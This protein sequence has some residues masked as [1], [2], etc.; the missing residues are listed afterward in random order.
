[1]FAFRSYKIPAMTT[2][3]IYSLAEDASRAESAAW[4]RFSSA[5]DRSEFCKSWLAILCLQIERVNGALLLLGP[6]RD[7]TYVPAAIWPHE[8]RD[9]QYL[10]PAAER[11]LTEKRG[12]VVA[13]D[14]GS[15][16]KRDQPAFVGYPIEVSGILHGVVVLDVPAGS[17]ASLQR[18][19]RLLHWASAWLIDE[20][21]KRAVQERD[22]RL[23]RLALAM[24][25]VATAIQERHLAPSL[26]ACANELAGRLNCERVSIG[27]ERSG[28]TE[29]R[30]IS[31]TA[32]FDTKMD[33]ARMI[34]EAM[35]EVLDLDVALVHPPRDEQEIPAIAHAE[36][37]R[38]FRDAAVCSVP[39]LDDG[40]AI[41]VVTFERGEGIFDIETVELCKT[42]G[43]LL[44]PILRL[45]R[46]SE[47]SFWHR[48]RIALGEGAQVLFG[49]RHPGAK[50]VALIIV[51]TLF[52]C[53][54]AT[55]V[56]RVAAR[57][58]IEG[59]VQR[60][61]A[62]PFDGYIL[63]TFV[64]AGDIVRSG[65]VLARLDDRDLKLEQ[66]R[67]NAER[68]QLLRKHRQALATQDRAAMVII[69]AQIDQAEAEL[70]LTTDKIARSKLVAPFDGVVV[71]GDLNQLLGTPVEQGK[72]LFQVAPLDAY[73]VILQ[74]EER[75]IAHV[76]VD[77]RGELTLSGIPDKIMDFT[78]TQIT[79]VSTSLEGRNY[80]RVEAHLA[81][82]SE[83]VR[84]GM[85]G[86]G[87]I[88]VGQRK[89]IWIWGH[90]LYDWMRLSIWKWMP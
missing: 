68:E 63:Q 56:Y 72:M 75:D 88:V 61:A 65:Q 29:V 36:L 60:V 24:D 30:T 80:F 28:S 39:L 2:A 66:S 55:G 69:A 57:T 89:L 12:L 22:A 17:E 3:P 59:A 44:G 90:S 45:K 10:S 67:L 62:A 35:D 6:D 53:S 50:L 9:V 42:I 25:I 32:T 82:A 78:L 13:S 48:G 49:P 38:E 31:H 1:L 73:R 71:S 79:P 18:A 46:D 84:P 43:G 14:G 7:G 83:R 76:A 34:G 16:A 87:K 47:R 20:F 33:L 19:L 74:V 64:R 11:V 52:V 5:N 86:L 27:F 54:V 41:G 37:A 21:R 85:E 23:S 15:V 40:H 8:G 26:L 81:N 58:V 51:G 70:S 77:Q 4:A